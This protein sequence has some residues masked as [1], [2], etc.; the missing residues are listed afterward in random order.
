MS[1]VNSKLKKSK[2]YDIVLLPNKII[3]LLNDELVRSIGESATSELNYEQGKKVGES[4]VQ[5]YVENNFKNIEKYLKKLIIIGYFS[6]VNTKS[7]EIR[8]PSKNKIVFTGK[9]LFDS[10]NL[11]SY[12]SNNSYII[13][14]LV[15]FISSLTKSEWKGRCSRSISK[16]DTVD[17]YI[18][19]AVK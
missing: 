3:S 4:M 19:E 15:G 7:T 10:K 12:S 17:E 11:K 9:S 16:G 18:I 13:G 5:G 14:E 2:E 1:S 8:M 6:G